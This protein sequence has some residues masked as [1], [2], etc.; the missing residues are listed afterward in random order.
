[1]KIVKLEAHVLSN[2]LKQS[3]FFSQ[4]AYNER[5]ICV[6]KISTDEGVYGWGEGYGPADVIQKGIALLEPLL[7]GKNPLENES[8]W[9]EMYRKTL[10]FARRSV[11]FAAVSAIDI[12]LWDIKGKA[13]N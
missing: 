1:M 5:R 9:F 3:F 13:V 7:I 4:W 2:K 11:L 10:D 8:L 6:V 12:A